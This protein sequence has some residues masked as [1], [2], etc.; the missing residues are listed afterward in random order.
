M[1]SR[2]TVWADVDISVSLIPNVLPDNQLHSFMFCYICRVCQVTSD[3]MFTNPFSYRYDLNRMPEG[4]PS[5][6]QTCRG[7]LSLSVWCSHVA[8]CVVLHVLP[9][10]II[11][12]KQLHPKSGTT[13]SPLELFQEYSNVH[14]PLGA[15]DGNLE[16]GRDRYR[17]V[18]VEIMNYWLEKAPLSKT[19]QLSKMTAGS[20]GWSFFVLTVSNCL[21]ERKPNILYQQ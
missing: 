12:Q 11:E 7:M 4:C 19:S 16:Q 6:Q 9:E 17:S 20:K 10:E 15:E 8:S 18:T 21:G 5:V 14:A 1:S 13:D 3:N 2:W